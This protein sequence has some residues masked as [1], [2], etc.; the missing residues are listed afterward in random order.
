MRTKTAFVT[1]A[2]S[3]IGQEIAVRFARL[4]MTV[5]VCARSEDR[6]DRVIRAV[7]GHGARAVP[8]AF[9]A[10]D[11]E[12]TRL[13]FE[14]FT[15]DHGRI[16]VAVN[17]AGGTLAVESPIVEMQH[18]DWTRVLDANLQTTWN[19]LQQEM[20]V[21]MAAG[22]GAIVNTIGALGVRGTDGMAAYVAAKHAVVGLTRTAAVEAAAAGVRVN[23]IAPSMTERFEPG[24]VAEARA[25]GA[26][27]A[28]PLGRIA[29]ADEAAA[30]AVWLCSDDAS[31]VTGHIL[32][33]D[34][35]LT[36]SP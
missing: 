13:A 30:C 33:V 29:T 5:A 31:F 19:C 23:G 21:M 1:G 34:G 3:A 24:D 9:D 14:R 28:L 4:G 6:L 12:D 10:R 15:T 26:A 7:E 16:D 2:S 27:S 8:L 20:R 25:Q 35:G 22:S 17:N 18:G 32:M 36:A 11:P